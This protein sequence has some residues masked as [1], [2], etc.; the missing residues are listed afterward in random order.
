M[1]S[2]K[3]P[4]SE[5]AAVETTRTIRRRTVARGAGWAAPVA[6]VAVSAPAFAASTSCLSAMWTEAAY[7]GANGEW[8]FCFAFSNCGTAEILVTKIDVY[9]SYHAP[10]TNTAV[11][12]LVHTINTSTTVR[13]NAHGANPTRL[14]TDK[15]VFTTPPKDGSSSLLP[16]YYNDFLPTDTD[17]EI[18]CVAKDDNDSAVFPADPL[19]PDSCKRLRADNTYLII[20]YTM[21]G[22]TQT[23]FLP[24]DDNVGCRVSAGCSG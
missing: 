8:S 1:S 4:Q 9:T 22:D 11:N 17:G 18:D 10:A 2:W 14:C 13:T 20:T 7:S 3:R 15:Q 19:Y 24:M 23:L 6:L 16:E 5:P 21:S 12:Q